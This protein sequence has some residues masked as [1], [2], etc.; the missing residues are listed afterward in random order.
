MS[1]LKKGWCYEKQYF[2]H[3]GP[4]TTTPNHRQEA[5]VG[6]TTAGLP[7]RQCLTLKAPKSRSWGEMIMS[8]RMTLWTAMGSTHGLRETRVITSRIEHSGSLSDKHSWLI[9]EG[10][11]KIMKN[12]IV[13]PTHF[14]ACFNWQIHS[15]PSGSRFVTITVNTFSLL[16]SREKVSSNHSTNPHEVTTSPFSRIFDVMSGLCVGVWP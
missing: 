11:F 5:E 14:N 7:G 15:N 4:P 9:C 1:L 6:L 16:I 2:A 13:P 10:I 12:P 3:E 8:H